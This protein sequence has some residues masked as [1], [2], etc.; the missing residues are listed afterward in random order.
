[1][2]LKAREEGMFGFRRSV[3]L[4]CLAA[5]LIVLPV[6][7][8]AAVKIS[9]KPTSNMKCSSGIC[10][11]T[12]KKAVLNVTDLAN[13]L[14]AGD[15]TVQSGS[16]AQEI[17]IDAAL[18]W[19]ST[20]RLTLDSYR[21]ITFNQPLTVAGTGALTITTNDGG[22]NGDF[23]FLDRGSVK[24]WDIHSSLVINGH[25]YMLFVS[26]KDFAREFRHFDG[27]GEYYAQIKNWNL[28]NK[29][30]ST[31]PVTTSFNGTFEGLGNEIS[32][33]TIRNTTTGFSG[34]FDSLDFSAV[35]RDVNLKQVDI[36]GPGDVGAL[37][38]G[39]IGM[40]ID[41]VHVSGQISAPAGSKVGGLVG[42]GSGL[43]VN[44]LSTATILVSG[45]AIVGGLIGRKVDDHKADVV[46]SYSTG[47]VSA[48]GTA[49]GGLI[50]ESLGNGTV[51][52]SYAIGNV[53]GANAAPAG[54]IIGI[55]SPSGGSSTSIMNSY[56]IGMVSGGSGA[57]VGGSIGEDDV[58]GG[59]TN[60]YWD[61]DTSGIGNPHQGAG[62]VPD[63]PGITG[64]TD[65]QLKSGLPAGFD[66][67]VWA[68]NP[69]INNGYPYLIANPP[70][71]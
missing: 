43:T 33:L 39:S 11:P 10:T 52:N 29:T 57:P 1:V 32:H 3:T 71:K 61:L 63:D 46:A 7:A 12:A 5:G 41:N 58:S 26:L 53:T 30:Y 47:P 22:S 40:V 55:R 16:L 4:F 8:F 6:T 70:P 15:V 50:G 27:T 36:S 13:M 54:G 67:K 24:I 9:S 60:D 17:D 37:A 51:L 66:P 23:Q 2:A 49:A 38:G 14:A 18:S 64:L 65:A 69:K 25:S 45:D 35:V 20:H 48:G 62:N 59:I 68:I 56:S 21:S 31:S 28:A 19:T 44:C 34:L 42:I